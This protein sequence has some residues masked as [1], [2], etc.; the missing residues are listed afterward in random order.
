MIYASFSQLIEMA[1]KKGRCILSIA[2]AHDIRVLKLVKLARKQKLIAPI[3]V[4]DQD[5]IIKFAREIDFNLTGVPIIDESDPYQASLIAAEQA[6]QNQAQV[7]MKGAVDS[8]VFLEA[9]MDKRRDLRTGGLLS[10]LAA[11]HIP[12]FPRLL[13]MTDAEFNINPQLNEKVSILNNAINY[14]HK[15][16]YRQ[17]KVAVLSANSEIIPYGEA[18]N[19]DEL[20][21]NYNQLNNA[22]I[23]GPMTLDLAINPKTVVLRR[24]KSNVAGQAQLLLAANMEMGSMIRKTLV[25]FA[26]A[27]H[28]GVVLGARVPLLMFSD[29]DSMNSRLASIALA[30]RRCWQNINKL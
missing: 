15:L 16:G 14:L 6:D 25:C 29:F 2:A 28:A 3:L 10:H 8:E 26:G 18:T 24:I 22:V 30:S 11:L 4:G 23:E 9:I 17:P 19:I 7:I 5:L 27:E 13:Y 20:T 21:Q 1:G 12:K